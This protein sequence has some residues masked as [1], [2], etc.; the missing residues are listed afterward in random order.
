MA[1]IFPPLPRRFRLESAM[2]SLLSLLRAPGQT[3]ALPKRLESEYLRQAA[4]MVLD[5]Q[6][7]EDLDERLDELI[8]DERVWEEMGANAAPSAPKSTEE[9][10]TDVR[11]WKLD[12]ES[13]TRVLGTTPARRCEKG[14]AAAKTAALNLLQ[15]TEKLS[16]SLPAALDADA[17]DE[18]SGNRTA[19]D[20]VYDLS[21]PSSLRELALGGLRVAATTLVIA[22][23]EERGERLEPFLALGLAN[24]WAEGPEALAAT[25]SS[26]DAMLAWVGR[27]FAEAPVATAVEPVLDRW[28]ADAEAA[29]ASV[30]FPLRPDASDVEAE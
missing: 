23:A 5:A 12:M 3:S 30:F 11:A 29:G 16:A 4:D 21:V 15:V 2:R 10:A 17:Q 1:A 18:D 28:A 25:T 22:R 6:S 14:L 9:M 20:L 26:G 19:L 13:L 24:A 7:L 27:L 8:G